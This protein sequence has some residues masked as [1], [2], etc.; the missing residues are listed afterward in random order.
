MLDVWEHFN[1]VQLPRHGVHLSIP[2]KFVSVNLANIGCY[3]YLVFEICSLFTLL[4][5]EFAVL[6]L[7]WSIFNFF[8]SSLFKLYTYG[9]FETLNADWMAYIMEWRPFVLMDELR[10]HHRKDFIKTPI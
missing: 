6:I 9:D 4:S 5:S 10:I 7:D 8:S 1:K 2:M 3:P